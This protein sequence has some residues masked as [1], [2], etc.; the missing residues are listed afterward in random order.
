[1][2]PAEVY[3]HTGDNPPG[4]D[5]LSKHENVVWKHPQ[6]GW[7]KAARNGSFTPISEADVMRLKGPVPSPTPTPGAVGN[8]TAGAMPVTGA[9]SI[10]PNLGGQRSVADRAEERRRAGAEKSHQATM[11]KAKFAVP[12]RVDP[13]AGLGLMERSEVARLVRG[14]MDQATAVAQVRKK[15]P[16]A[17]ATQA[18]GLRQ[19]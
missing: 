18:E 5:I 7:L 1:M 6:H 16:P 14:G 8:P 11:D 10:D 17:A 13:L 15:M 19:E 3:E 9:G 4:L 2:M 12:E